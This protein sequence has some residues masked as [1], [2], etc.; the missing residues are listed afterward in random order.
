MGLSSLSDTY[1]WSTRYSYALPKFVGSSLV[2][3]SFSA[4]C[5][6]PAGLYIGDARQQSLAAISCDL[7]GLGEAALQVVSAQRCPGWQVVFSQ[8]G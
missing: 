4:H 3:K 7:G 2:P 6:P 5:H 1:P 8:V